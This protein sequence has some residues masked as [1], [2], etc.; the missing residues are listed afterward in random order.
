MSM[1]KSLDSMGL[2]GEIFLLSPS[3]LA[4]FLAFPSVFYLPFLFLPSFPFLVPASAPSVCYGF[5]TLASSG[6]LTNTDGE[7]NIPEEGIAKAKAQ[8]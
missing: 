7:K 3:L 8:N 1:F 4:P 6:V 2:R 5:L